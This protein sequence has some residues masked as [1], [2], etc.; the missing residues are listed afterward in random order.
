MLSYKYYLNTV[1]RTVS[2]HTATVL[3]CYHIN[4]T[5]TYSHLPSVN[6]HLLSFIL[7]CKYYFNIVTRTITLLYV[8][9]L[10]IVPKLSVYIT[11]NF[12]SKYISEH[13][14]LLYTLKTVFAL[15]ANLAT[16]IF[17]VHLVSYFS[18]IN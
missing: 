2:K 12:I 13:S 5:L 10:Q 17:L 7:S 3:S 1:T 16:N 9:I 6:T 14:P 4:I 15:L 8:I 18:T 11:R